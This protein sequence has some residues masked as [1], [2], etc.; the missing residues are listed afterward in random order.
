MLFLSYTAF[1]IIAPLVILY[2]IGYRPQASSPIPRSVGVILADAAPNGAQVSINS[3]SYGSLPRSIPNIDPSV[4]HVQ[5]A[6]DGYTPWEKQLEVKPTQATDIR[7]VQLLPSTFDTDSITRNSTQFETSPNNLLIA[8]ATNKNTLAVYDDTGAMVIPEEKLA[9][10]AIAISWSPDS[11]HILVT[12]SK[13]TYQLFQVN[14]SSLTKVPSKSLTGLTTIHWSPSAVNAIYALDKNR[15]LVSYTIATQRSETLLKNINIFTIAGR[16]LYYQ[17]VENSLGVLQLRS[18]DDRILVP[19]ATK[20]VKKISATGDGHVALLG[21]DGELVIYTPKLERLTV[22]AFAQDMSWSPDDKLLLVQTAPTELSIFNVDNERLFSIHLKDLHM[23]TR[24][25]QPITNARWFP[26]SLHILY[27]TNGALMF[28]EI[29]TR[30]HPIA[31]VID[32]NKAPGHLVFGDESKSIFY[33]QH[34]GKETNLVQTW[35]V[36]QEDR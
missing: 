21:R 18:K 10:R 13:N 12:F 34:K 27:E 22:S 16:S 20:A 11:S 1:V 30:D 17:T 26:D 15:S 3:I 4:V 8:N 28:S 33:L 36:T 5:I 7:S 29:D 2:A 19:D 32:S 6:K 9:G 24:L 25:S 14:T 23:V 31:Q 35:L